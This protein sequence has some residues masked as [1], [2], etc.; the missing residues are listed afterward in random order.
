[1]LKNFFT[2][3]GAKIVLLLL[4]V[5]VGT[6]VLPGCI[7][8]RGALARGWAGGVVENDILY[9]G[10]MA[11][12]IVAVNLT[13]GRLQWSVPLK[14]PESSGGGLLGCAQGSTTVPIYG[15]PAVSEGLVYV[16][17]Y[18]GKIY[19]FNRDEVRDDPRWVYP[20]QEFIGG[21]IVGG[22]VFRDDKLYFA[23]G[24]N[25]VYALDAPDGYKEWEFETGDKIWSTPAVDGD[26]LYIGSFDKKLYALDTADG[27]KKWEFEV[28]GAIVSTP[29]V[30]DNTVYFGS[31]DRYLY[32]VNTADG[33]LRWKYMADRW[34]WAEPVVYDGTVYAACLDGKIYA[35][36]AL[37][38]S[39]KV[40][41][42]LGGPVSSTPVVVD[43]MLIAA[44]QDG[45]VYAI[46]TGSSRKRDLAALG[47]NVYA[48]LIAGSG[49]V[50][51]H[52]NT[53]ALHE[54]DVHTGAKR[55]ID[56]KD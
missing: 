21:A 11:G 32:A 31:F 34:F 19:A 33:S 28:E 6:V 5:L 22:V 48:P 44:T 35:L 7:G 23:S 26:T 20:R 10:S 14:V 56:I 29:V 24:D 13:D 8:S 51:I 42:D 36:D 4:I 15:T 41:F 45:M 17:G 27:S 37:N 47:E 3:P 50:Y 9:T 49:K 2:K 12:N 52:T 55:E 54:I 40:E 1:M 43:G 30:H 18:T 39:K 16:G 25:K 46:D 53:D 38:G